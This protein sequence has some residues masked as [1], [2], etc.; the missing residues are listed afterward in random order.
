MRDSSVTEPKQRFSGLASV[1]AAGRPTYP[2]SAIDFIVSKCNLRTG[3]VM[4]DVGCGTG[5]SS[6]IFAERNVQVLGIEPND[7]MRK[8]AEEQRLQTIDYSPKYVRGE[9]E[10]TGL[11]DH[12]VDVVLAAQAFHWFRPQQAI[13][14]FCR[15]LKPGGW[16]VLIWNER[17]EKD[18]F[19]GEYGELIRQFPDT[20]QVEM[21]R[22]KAGDAL[23]LD[24]QVR[25]AS[26]S[27]FLNQQEMDWHGLQQRAFSTSYAPKDPQGKEALVEGLQRLY[28]KYQADGKLT[29]HYETSVYLAESPG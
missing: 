3:S 14:E 24:P 4:A 28:D 11:P 21:K 8:Q 9:A 29:M 17:N 6:R 19:T 15:V 20:S 18:S 16:I 2:D 1:Y 27:W 7:D 13:A 5:I 25:N 22:R 26:L 23:L 10:A 12:S